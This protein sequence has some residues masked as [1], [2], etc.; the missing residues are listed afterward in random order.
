MDN[1]LDLYNKQVSPEVVEDTAVTPQS[2]N[3]E[4]QQ[5]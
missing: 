1:L 4:M 2:S 5:A 3:P